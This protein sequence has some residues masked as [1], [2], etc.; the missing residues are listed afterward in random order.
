[1]EQLVVNTII[2]LEDNSEYAVIKTFDIDGIR[3]AYVINTKSQDDDGF[4]TVEGDI[5][6]VVT[7]PNVI[8]KLQE[9][10]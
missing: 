10:L 8:L 3:Y 4:I 9:I 1:M 7:D 2:T 5:L 6:K